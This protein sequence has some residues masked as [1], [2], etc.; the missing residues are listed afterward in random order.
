MQ[1][2]RVKCRTRRTDE[3]R[4][5]V[6]TVSDTDLFHFDEGRESFEDH[7]QPN[8]DTLWYARDFMEWL[9]YSSYPTFQKAV[10]TAIGVC[11]T[12]GIPVVE[13]FVQVKRNR[14][15]QEVN[16]HKLSRFACYTDAHN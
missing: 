4:I 10:N 14:D 1:G 13:N 16:D 8:G 15:G 6:P 5:I 12:L 7:G 11:S 3:K 9:G 2:S